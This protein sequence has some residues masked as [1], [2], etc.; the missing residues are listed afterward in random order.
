MHWFKESNR[1]RTIKPYQ[2]PVVCSVFQ[3]RIWQPLSYPSSHLPL[4]L[5]FFCS[6]FFWNLFCD[7]EVE[8]STRFHCVPAGPTSSLSSSRNPHTLPSPLTR[9]PSLTLFSPRC[10]HFGC[11]LWLMRARAKLP[12]LCSCVVRTFFPLKALPPL[13]MLMLALFM[14]WLCCVNLQCVRLSDQPTL[15][16]S[17]DACVWYTY[18][19]VW[20]CACWC[21]EKLINEKMT[22][23]DWTVLRS[24]SWS[25][26]HKLHLWMGQRCIFLHATCLLWFNFAS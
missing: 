7:S 22:L 1:S 4:P 5:C 2:E 21:L 6:V 24:E 23:G 13:M 8:Q 14:S 18:T 17:C 9:S 12:L 10:G 20:P 11:C 19:C 25:R 26:E 3:K 16:L 15:D